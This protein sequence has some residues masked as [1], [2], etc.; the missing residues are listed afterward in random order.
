MN[1]TFAWLIAATSVSGIAGC[2]QP[3]PDP[4]DATAAPGG[5]AEQVSQWEQQGETT[6]VAV[7]EGEEDAELAAAIAEARSTAEEAR[8]RWAASPPA[9]RGKWA[10]KWAAPTRDG[11]LEHV[12]VQPERWSPF[13]IEGLLLSSPLGELEC[14]RGAGELVSLPVEE[15]SDWIHLPD[16]DFHGRREGGFTVRLLEKRYGVPEGD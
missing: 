1:T 11:H 14:G 2:E 12:W 8:Q 3:P 6:L 15:L 5:A 4:P 13:R 10:V 9:E 16:G 7:P